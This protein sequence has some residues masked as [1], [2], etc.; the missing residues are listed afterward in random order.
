MNAKNTSQILCYEVKKQQER[1]EKLYGTGDYA[2]AIAKNIKRMIWVISG[3]LCLCL[4]LLVFQIYNANLSKQGVIIDSEG[5]ITSFLRPNAG[6]ETILMEA[7]IFS[8]SGEVLSDQALKLMITPLQTEKQQKSEEA[9]E[10]SENKV[11]TTQHEI[12]NAIYQLNSD[13]TDRKVTLPHELQDG[14]KIYWV[15]TE[16]QNGWTILFVGFIGGYAIYHKRDARLVKAEKEARESILRELPEFVNKMILLL[17][18]G[19]ILS[20][21]FNKIVI[22]YQKTGGG[23]NNYFYWIDTGLPLGFIDGMDVSQQFR[24][25]GFIGR[26]ALGT[27]ISFDEMEK[28]TSATM[29][30]VFPEG[31][32][33][34]HTKSCSIVASYPIQTVLNEEIRKRYKPCSKCGSDVAEN[35]SLVCCYQAYG[36]AYHLLSCPTVDKYIISMEKDQAES[37][38]YTPCLKCGGVE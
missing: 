31:G 32:K 34:Y 10:M 5:H 16:P 23:D 22:D 14:T 26:T 2:A 3:F 36:E 12:R 24:C 35:G 6:E 29:V 13:T 19:L 15:P 17:N 20:N 1:F 27:P 18:A 9:K 7:N 38:G 11:D 28:N 8:E 30:W 33:R 25:R 21:A 37:R 4:S